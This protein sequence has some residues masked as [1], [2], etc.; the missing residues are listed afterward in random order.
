MEVAINHL[1]TP[2]QIMIVL[3]KDWATVATEMTFH[4]EVEIHLVA[5]TT[6][7]AKI[8]CNNTADHTLVLQEVDS[9]EEEALWEHLN[10]VGSNLE[11]AE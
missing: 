1:D 2:L 11:E 5:L 9:V 7:E 3:L 8:Q 4:I 6:V 10:G